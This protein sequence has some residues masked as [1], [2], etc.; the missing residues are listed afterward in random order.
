M[1]D[2]VHDL[3]YAVRTLRRAPTF[4]L[5]AL[6]TL[7]LGVA[8]ATTISSVV[9]T[10]LLRPLPYRESDRLVRVI[11]NA[12]HPIAGR[13]PLQRG[14][15]MNELRDWRERT[16][17]FRESTAVAPI[18][19]RTVRT[20]NGWAG[21]WGLAVA[22]DTFS[23]LG[24]QPVLGRAIDPGDQQDADVVMLSHGIWQRH[25]NANPAIVGTVVEFRTGALLSPIPPRLLK[26]IGVLPASFEFPTGMFDFYIPLTGDGNSPRVT[27]IARLP[28]D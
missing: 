26:V 17:A 27:L 5:T 15:P 6:L 21:L 12:P 18:A 3:R 24:V 22:Y 10:I 8:A 16:R 13:P 11:E 25:F 7:A 28:A 1:L 23:V 19:Q 2:L 4:T 14:L 9:E 20:A